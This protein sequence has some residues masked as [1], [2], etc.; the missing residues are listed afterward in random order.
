MDSE[1]IDFKLSVLH[2]VTLSVKSREYRGNPIS[3]VWII[4]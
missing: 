3:W 1:N 2:T 4:L